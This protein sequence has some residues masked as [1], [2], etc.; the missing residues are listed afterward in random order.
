MTKQ[1]IR[2]NVGTPELSQPWRGERVPGRPQ[3]INQ[4]S[5]DID[6]YSITDIISNLQKLQTKYQKDYTDLEIR[7]EYDCGCRE[8]CS[9]GPT[10]YVSG[11]RLE[12]DIEYDYR[13]AKETH[14]ANTKIAREREQYEALKKKFESDS[15]SS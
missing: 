14:Y 13:I 7:S 12:S 8:V 6:G 2:V 11:K 5:V 1:I 15:T 9:C 10:Y 3:I 4:C